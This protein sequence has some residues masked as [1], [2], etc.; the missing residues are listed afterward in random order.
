MAAFPNIDN[1]QNFIR[2]EYYLYGS[3]VV[4]MARNPH[5]DLLGS[6]EYLKVDFDHDKYHQIYREHFDGD[7]A[8]RHSVRYE[9]ACIRA[10]SPM[11][12]MRFMEDMSDVPNVLAIFLNAFIENG[13]RARCFDK[14][15]YYFPMYT[16]A[17]ARVIKSVQHYWKGRGGLR[18]YIPGRN[19]RLASDFPGIEVGSALEE[20]FYLTEA[21]H[22]AARF[23]CPN[24]INFLLRELPD[25]VEVH[26]EQLQKQD[27]LTRGHLS[28]LTA[29]HHAAVVLAKDALMMMLERGVDPTAPDKKDNTFMHA[30]AVSTGEG[31][32]QLACFHAA[33]KFLVETITDPL[34]LKAF[35]QT[36]NKDGK[37]A[38]QLAAEAKNKELVTQLLFVM[39]ADMEPVETHFAGM[40]IHYGRLLA[41]RIAQIDREILG[42]S[43]SIE[44]LQRQ[45][46]E[47]TAAKVELQSSVRDL[48]RLVHWQQQI[49]MVMATSLFAAGMMPAEI[50]PLLAAP[51]A[52]EPALLA[53]G[54]AAPAAPL[55][56]DLGV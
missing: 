4:S 8:L 40:S 23:N 3:T 36:E 43:K 46:I 26:N 14:E 6:I 25:V 45:V 19:V 24:I 37:I 39:G 20:R 35:Y 34:A 52:A 44:E 12:A 53:W 15:P 10:L 2:G 42:V 5:A 33:N 16:A 29:L 21:T 41:E 1:I 22:L 17:Q 18:L 7:E 31:E 9:A 13:F 32:D 27:N 47:N 11:P 55:E 28:G 54:E 56:E 48:T 51:P 49:I 50:V 38:L 30:L